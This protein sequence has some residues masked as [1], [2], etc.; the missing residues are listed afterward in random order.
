MYINKRNSHDIEKVSLHDAFFENIVYNNSE[1]TISIDFKSE[2]ED[3]N[4]CVIFNDVLYYEMVCCNFWGGGYNVI[5][6]TIL[7][8]TVIFDK[9]L[10]LENVEK[11]RSYSSEPSTHEYFGIEILVN[12]GDRFKIIC[13]SINISTI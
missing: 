10:R 5:C 1:K 7:D 9:L 6:W 13:K 8:T 11:A 12:S 4:N 2:W 3:K